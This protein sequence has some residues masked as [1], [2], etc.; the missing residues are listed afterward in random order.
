[1]FAEQ[2]NKRLDCY[3]HLSILDPHET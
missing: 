1:L 2:T 3:Q